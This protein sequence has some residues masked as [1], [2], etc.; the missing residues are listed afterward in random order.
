MCKFNV[1]KTTN[2]AGRSVLHFAPW[3]YMEQAVQ[4]PVHAPFC[5][6]TP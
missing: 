1:H 4:A 2:K 5:S 3:S 6:T